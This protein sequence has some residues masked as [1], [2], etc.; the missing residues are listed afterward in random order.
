MA[1]ITICLDDATRDA[2]Q[3]HADARR[4]SMS[5]FVRT[6]LED[7]VDRFRIDSEIAPTGFHPDT[8]TPQER[9]QLALLHRILA[10]VLPEN[11]FHGD[12]D[13]DREYQL[14]RAK[15]LEKGFT[16]EYRVEFAG[17]DTELT[18][19]DSSFVLDV[20]DMFRC[21]Q[22][23]VKRLR[24][25]GARVD[26][27][28]EYAVSFRGFDI[29]DRLEASMLGYVR[30]LVS[31]GS[32][33]KQRDFMLD[34]GSGNS[35]K[36]MYEVYSRMLTEYRLIRESKPPFG[37]SSSQLLLLEELQRLAAAG[38]HPSRR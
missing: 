11:A 27:G 31:H 20:L 25:E 10:R 21:A 24:D 18:R 15:V 13:R 9:H 34:A 26:D 16:H 1:T 3:E 23:S 12:G 5:E 7:A 17:I 30:Y 37:H 29:N 6:T 14:E 2:L 19:R 36:R 8:M 4:V 35:D 32:W 22:A 33:E 28:L 38:V